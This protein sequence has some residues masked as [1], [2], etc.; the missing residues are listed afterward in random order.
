[1]ILL[2]LL[3]ELNTWM[4]RVKSNQIKFSKAEGSRWSLTLPEWNGSLKGFR[5]E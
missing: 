2:A 4:D 3:L 1:M 5:F